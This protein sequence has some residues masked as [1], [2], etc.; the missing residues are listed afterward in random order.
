MDRAP[1]NPY[2]KMNNSAIIDV[3]LLSRSTNGDSNLVCQ[4]ADIVND[5][6]PEQLDQIRTAIK[7]G[8]QLSVES[9]SRHLEGVLRDMGAFEA[10]NNASVL[11]SPTSDFESA[12][13]QTDVLEQEIFSALK[14]IKSIFRQNS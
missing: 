14:E 5:Y 12:H 7:N 9:K 3:D 4:L 1:L 6:Y 2:N 13:Q 10:A 11:F 8:D